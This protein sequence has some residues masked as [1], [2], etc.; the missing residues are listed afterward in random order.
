M[1]LEVAAHGIFESGSAFEVA[2]EGVRDVEDALDVLHAEGLLV[3]DGQGLGG[4]DCV[5]DLRISG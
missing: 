4:A 1:T 2:I 3:I 5:F